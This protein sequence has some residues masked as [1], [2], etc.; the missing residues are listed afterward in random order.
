MADNF[1]IDP[2]GATSVAAD[3]IGG[4]LFPRS[5]L[6]HG[7]DGTNDGDVSSSNPFPVTGSPRIPSTG[8]FNRPADTFA[9]AF[10]D[11][12]ANSTTAGSVTPITI[13]AARYASPAQPLP[14][15][16]SAFIS[17]TQPRPLP[18]A[19]TPRFRPRLQTG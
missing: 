2:T 16:S 9:Y 7:A 18:M 19:I 13:T 15:L 12:V 4:I 8:S 14:S 6:I 10:G 17:S 5:K 11:L 1:N 3:D